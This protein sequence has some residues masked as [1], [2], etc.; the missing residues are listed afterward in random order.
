MKEMKCFEYG[1]CRSPI[2]FPPHFYKLIKWHFYQMTYHHFPPHFLSWQNDVPVKRHITHPL[3]YDNWKNDTLTKW[4]CT[5]LLI[6]VSQQNDTLMKW[7]S[8]FSLIIVSQQN[9]LSMKCHID[10]PSYLIIGKMTH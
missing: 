1:P 3:I 9:D 8:T 4:Q 10:Y 7:H 5:L 2:S 6:I